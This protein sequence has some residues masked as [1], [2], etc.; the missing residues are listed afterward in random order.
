MSSNSAEEAAHAPPLSVHEQELE[1][2]YDRKYDIIKRSEPLS[3][4][5]AENALIWVITAA[6]PFKS[7][8]LFAA[9]QMNVSDNPEDGPD[10][11]IPSRCSNLID[12]MTVNLCQGLLEVDSQE[13]RSRHCGELCLSFLINAYSVLARELIPDGVPSSGPVGSIFAYAAMTI[14]GIFPRR[15]SAPP[16]SFLEFA[17]EDSPF[18][19][20]A[21][22]CWYVHFQGPDNDKRSIRTL[23]KFIGTPQESSGYFC[24]W[25]NCGVSFFRFTIQSPSFKL[26]TEKD[27][28]MRDVPDNTPVFAM[29]Y[30]SLF[31]PVEDWWANGEFDLSRCNNW[32]ESLL[33]IAAK[34][35]FVPLSTVRL[36]VERWHAN[37]DLL[38]TS[39]FYGSA[40]AAAAVAGRIDVMRYLVSTAHANASLQLPGRHGN[41]LLAAVYCP[42]SLDGVRF[43]VEEAKVDVN[44]QVLDGGSGSALDAAALE[45]NSAALEYLIEE[46]GADVNI[47]H[48]NGRYVNPLARAICCFEVDIVE[49][50]L[51]AGASSDYSWNAGSL[52]TRAQPVQKRDTEDVKALECKAKIK[53]M[54]C[55]SAPNFW[56]EDSFA[57]IPW[58][59]GALHTREYWMM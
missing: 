11:I 6:R 46:G 23:K 16:E 34:V 48:L 52:E 24:L 13:H 2:T 12:Q 49:K 36:L 43:L 4:L 44:M 22:S 42:K 7:A 31:H 5:F 1:A 45:E 57:K 47:R 30:L 10:T 14:H 38:I 40:L 20:Y 58:Y 55:K 50:L 35:D 37:V 33:V 9:I 41:A 25:M 54:L 8:E 51:A 32:G 53:D 26:V 39:K 56:N 17:S 18:Y 21:K 28:L 59:Y 19:D 27:H 15:S 29:A 3:R